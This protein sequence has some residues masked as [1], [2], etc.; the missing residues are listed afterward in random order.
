MN[1]YTPNKFEFK[2]TSYDGSVTTRTF[3]K[4]TLS[5]V[6]EEFEMFLKGCG[7]IVNGV[8]DIIEE[9]VTEEEKEQHSPYYYDFY[10]NR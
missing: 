9:D 10:R 5:E 1:D 6:L 8:V 3:Y 2:M 7:F 4:D